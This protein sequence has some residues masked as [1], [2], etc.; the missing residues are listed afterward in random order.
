VDKND[1]PKNQLPQS[2]RLL[3]IVEML[4]GKWRLLDIF[5]A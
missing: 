4:E 5:I 3:V 2:R 1:P